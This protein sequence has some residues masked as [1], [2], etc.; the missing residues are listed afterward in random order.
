[1]DDL[2]E[3]EVERLISGEDVTDPLAVTLQSM[4]EHFASVRPPA[5]DTRLSA[6]VSAESID[7][8]FESRSPATSRSTRNKKMM[9]LSTFVGTAAG[10]ILIGASV[11]A[12][13]VGGAQASGVVDVPL[14]PDAAEETSPTPTEDE[15]AADAEVDVQF[16]TTTSTIASSTTVPTTT[17]TEHV[18]TTIIGPVGSNV[19]VISARSFDVLDA[20]QVTI[21]GDSVNGVAVLEAIPADGWTAEIELDELG[22]AGVNFR[23][24]EDRVDFRAEIEDGA[25]RVRFRDRRIDSVDELWFDE[26]GNVITEPSDNDSADDEDDPNDDDLEDD[27]ADDDL[28][29]DDSD[30]DDRSDNSGKGNSD[31]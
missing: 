16:D 21:E 20:G 7:G 8:Y 18:D 5:P 28:D 19:V 12:A 26:D 25:L 29:E 24:G 22:E 1:M 14:L 13:S 31:D 3:T 11:A 4:R 10:K 23:R 6:L 9:S 30:D 2:D 27:D 17:T 15:L